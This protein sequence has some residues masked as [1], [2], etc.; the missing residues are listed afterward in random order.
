MKRIFVMLTVLIITSVYT[1][2]VS[3]SNPIKKLDWRFNEFRNRGIVPEDV[4]QTKC[5]LNRLYH[6]WPEQNVALPVLELSGP[7]QCK[8]I[9]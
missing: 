7:I 8:D 6:N 2:P 3:T 5:I 1:I 9:D 4:F